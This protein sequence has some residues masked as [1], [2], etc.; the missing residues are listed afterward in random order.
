MLFTKFLFLYTHTRRR[1]YKREIIILFFFGKCSLTT[2]CNTTT[3]R[4]YLNS[5]PSS[6]DLRK[7]YRWKISEKKSINLASLNFWILQNFPFLSLMLEKLFHIDWAKKNF[8]E[9]CKWWN[10]ETKNRIFLLW[11][12]KSSFISLHNTF[13]LFFRVDFFPIKIPRID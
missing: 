11:F 5:I 13:S 9:L 1:R 4:P 6:L 10:R 12:L 2:I 3:F 7:N 8:K